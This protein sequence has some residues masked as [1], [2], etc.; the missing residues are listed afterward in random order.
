MLDQ[1]GI[2]GHDRNTAKRLFESFLRVLLW[3]QGLS[4]LFLLATSRPVDPYR[5]ASVLLPFLSVA[6]VRWLLRRDQLD[7]AIQIMLAVFY[8]A[9]LPNLYRNGATAGSTLTVPATVPLAALLLGFRWGVW[10]GLL[11][12]GTIGGFFMVEHLGWRTVDFTFPL[13][14]W[15]FTEILVVFAVVFYQV[16][17]IMGLVSALRTANT[18]DRELAEVIERMEA[19]NRNLLVKV[20]ERT[21][22]L[23]D[24][25]E[26]LTRMA[27]T[28]SHDLRIPLRSIAGFAKVLGEEPM[29]ES[30]QTQL[31]G[32]Q[33]DAASLQL[34]LE[35][36]M[37]NLRRESIS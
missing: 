15:A 37:A 4:I 35:K 11:N 34:V 16:I 19:H 18:E 29:P 2:L 1:Q 33:T 25:N 28:L 12:I 22:G 17:P 23:R 26:S 20:E 21:Q 31:A 36:T 27:A 9:L 5:L 13:V 7:L 3:L 10:Y 32:I 14:N 8:I 30:V 24:A 6:V